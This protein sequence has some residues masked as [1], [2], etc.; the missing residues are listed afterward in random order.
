MKRIVLAVIVMAATLTTVRAKDPEPAVAA[1]DIDLV[2]CLDVSNSMDGLI[3]SAKL[4][5]WDIVNELARLKPVPNLRVGLYSY[6][7]SRYSR[8][9]GWVRKELDL[10]T[11]L[12]EVYNKLNALRTNGGEEY[13]ARV[14]QTAL[15][16]QKWSHQDQALKL[17][18]VCGNEPANQDR[19]VK[20]E[21]AAKQMNTAAV[22]VN[23]IYCGNADN[24]ECRGWRDYAKWSKGRF[25]S[26]DQDKARKSVH[27][28]TPYDG[29]LNKLSVKLNTTYVRYGA[30]GEKGAANQTLQDTAAANNAPAAGAARA[31]SKAEALY[32]NGTWDLVDRITEDPKYDVTTLK[33][34]DLPEEMKTLKP[35]ERMEY[36]KKKA[37]QRKAIQKE[38]L[39]LNVKRQ[40]HLDDEAKKQPKTAGEVALDDALRTIIREQ[41]AEKGFEVKK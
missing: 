38:I 25:A 20:L 17:I 39:A 30:A 12:D 5:L 21:D 1:R 18:F 23:T 8:E 26:I 41:A 3:D 11:D 14:T 37:D 40:K 9:S 31:V 32:R 34:E 6:G 19:E 13:V 10:T 16:E 36:L 35:E 15:L 22:K 27:V 29:D 24:G 28:T 33:A 4:K 7:H 2:L